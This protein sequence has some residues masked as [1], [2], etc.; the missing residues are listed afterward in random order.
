MVNTHLLKIPYLT[1]KLARQK[2]FT[3]SPLE[4]HLRENIRGVQFQK[5]FNKCLIVVHNVGRIFYDT[6]NSDGYRSRKLRLRSPR[7]QHNGLLY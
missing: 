3:N 2:T 6:Y 7:V 1:E 5:Y 4:V